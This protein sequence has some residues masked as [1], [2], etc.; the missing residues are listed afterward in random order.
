[1]TDGFVAQPS[2]G[3]STCTSTDSSYPLCHRPYRRHGWAR[4]SDRSFR[5]A[6]Q[7]LSTKQ[8]RRGFPHCLRRGQGERFDGSPDVDGRCFFCVS[9]GTY[10]DSGIFQYQHGSDLASFAHG[11]FREIISA[12]E[13]TTAS[14]TPMSSLLDN[15]FS[16]A[17]GRL[18]EPYFASFGQEVRSTAD[19]IASWWMRMSLGRGPV[20]KAFA[21]IFGYFL[22]A[23][24]LAVYMN[25]LTVGTIKNAEKALRTA[26]RQQLLV[27]KVVSHSASHATVWD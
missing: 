24:G 25:I 9:L 16:S 21:I 1:M 18:I 13:G 4:A 26:V 23:I 22:I 2:A 3:F 8:H 14:D 11:R 27:V 10:F 5:T 19:G 12:F 6:A 7:S 20:E 17:L 15:G